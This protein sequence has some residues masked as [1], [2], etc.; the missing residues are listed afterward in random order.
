MTCVLTGHR[1]L[2]K[3]FDENRLYDGLESL[4][5]S[6]YDRFLC[7][8]AMGF[9]LLALE[10]LV[11]LRRKYRFTI[12]ACVPFDGQ[13]TAFPYAE[14]KKYRELIA[15]CDVV[16]I[17]FSEYRDGCYLARDRFMADRADLLYAYCTRERGGTAYTVNY[18]KKK[19]VEVRFY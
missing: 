19:G 6:G 2:P 12:E 16:H 1:V 7:G 11:S 14:K 5:R 3:D 10:C 8:M 4:I 18:A 9:D 15:W 13:E 17:L